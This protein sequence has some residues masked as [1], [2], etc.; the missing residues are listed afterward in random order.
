MSHLA[1]NCL[2]A[3]KKLVSIS[4]WWLNMTWLVN[5]EINSF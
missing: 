3:V 2:I 4:K 1:Y 5:W